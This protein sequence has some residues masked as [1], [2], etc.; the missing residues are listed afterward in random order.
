M[1]HSERRPRGYRRRGGTS[2]SALSVNCLVHTGRVAEECMDLIDG[3]IVTFRST[4][5]VF[6]RNL[7][8]TVGG[9]GCP[10]YGRTNGLRTTVRPRL[11]FSPRATRKL[12]TE[13][14]WSLYDGLQVFYFVRRSGTHTSRFC[15]SSAFRH[16]YGVESTPGVRS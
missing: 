2:A 6:V 5:F 12:H 16:F 13:T 7:F 4:I 1:R 10:V 15:L 3:R 11:G 8:V 14:I 9:E